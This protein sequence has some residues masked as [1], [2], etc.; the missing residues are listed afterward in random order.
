[1]V[2]VNNELFRSNISFDRAGGGA[3]FPAKPAVSHVVY[4]VDEA[5]AKAGRGKPVKT[6]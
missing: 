4:G 2:N 5:L 3:V 1:M 6:G